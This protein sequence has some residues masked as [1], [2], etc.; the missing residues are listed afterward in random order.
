MKSSFKQRFIEF[1]EENTFDKSDCD[2]SIEILFT[3]LKEGDDITWNQ[4]T[5]NMQQILIDFEIE[6][7]I[8][9]LVPEDA[10]LNHYLF[11]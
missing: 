2:Y 7:G 8:T 11:M 3:Y 6:S 10:Q 1:I 9:G 5:M 4:L